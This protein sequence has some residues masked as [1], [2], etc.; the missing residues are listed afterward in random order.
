MRRAAQPRD[1]LDVVA[2]ADVVIA[3][4]AALSLAVVY[5]SD[6]VRVLSA[7]AATADWP[8]VPGTLHGKPI[9]HETQ[10]GRSKNYTLG[11]A[12]GYVVDG[13]AYNGSSVLLDAPYRIGG[14][15]DA[16]SLAVVPKDRPLEVFYDP[17][18]RSRSTLVRGIPPQQWGD[19]LYLIPL[20]L[21]ALL[22]IGWAATELRMRAARTIAGHALREHGTVS[23]LKIAAGTPL[24]AGGC[25]GLAVALLAMMLIPAFYGV[26]VGASVALGAAIVAVVAG[27]ALG[28]YEGIWRMKGFGA[29]RVD[30][31]ARQITLPA[32]GFAWRSV[33]INADE[34]EAI[35]IAAMAPSDA[36]SSSEPSPV[37]RP[38]LRQ[39]DA[40]RTK[41]TVLG[42]RLSRDHA[43]A[44]TRP[45]LL[46]DTKPEPLAEAAAWLSDLLSIPVAA[47]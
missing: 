30:R 10:S 16:E 44:G 14:Y 19:Q 2:P 47:S 17:S 23:S 7:Q 6:A 32:H 39:I 36:P 25:A 41:A 9:F 21:F 4:I 40:A 38:L 37:P 29:I 24:Q 28:V 31:V 12:F 35:V 20:N 8:S 27:V 43:A 46:T 34:I 11:V 1:V 15:A 13:V 33:T 18:A 26:R 3:A 45:V 42:L 22:M 5:D